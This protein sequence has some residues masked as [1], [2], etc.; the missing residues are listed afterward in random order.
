[1]AAIT[2]TEEIVANADYHSRLI[3]T[4][5][6]IEYAGP[7]ARNH[8]SYVRDLERQLEES[9]KK[10]EELV[11]ATS[12]ERKDHERLRD[13]TTKKLAAR[14]TGKKEKFEQEQLKEEQ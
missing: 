3:R 14:L 8:E 4:L 7:A 6:E 5:S 11:K 2:T 1:M 13:S 12:K 10:I 9:N